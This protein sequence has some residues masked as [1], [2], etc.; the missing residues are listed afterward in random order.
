MKLVMVEL[1]LN[2]FR[3]IGCSHGAKLGKR[4]TEEDAL[5]YSDQ[6]S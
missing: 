6:I 2:F 5:D 3:R 1:L 4:I